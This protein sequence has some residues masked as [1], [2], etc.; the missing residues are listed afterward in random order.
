[1][2]EWVE[3]ATRHNTHWIGHVEK[4]RAIGD[5]HFFST[6]STKIRLH[7]NNPTEF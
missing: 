1:L 3:I 6:P 4:R 7:W 2:S 5:T